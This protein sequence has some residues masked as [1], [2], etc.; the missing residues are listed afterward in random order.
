MR[1]VRSSGGVQTISFLS[2]SHVISCPFLN[3]WGVQYSVQIRKALTFRTVLHPDSNTGGFSACLRYSLSIAA[4]CWL[5]STKLLSVQPTD[6]LKEVRGR[7]PVSTGFIFILMHLFSSSLCPFWKHPHFILVLRQINELKLIHC[8]FLPVM[9][10]L[11]SV[12]C[13]WVTTGWLILRPPSR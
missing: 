3:L 6:T 10:K 7:K 11:F 2:R 13:G 5:V 8:V 9:C 4:L 12:L 1:R